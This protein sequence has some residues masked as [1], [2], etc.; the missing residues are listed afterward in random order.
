M[1]TQSIDQKTESIPLI[2]YII[3]IKTMESIC[4]DMQTV[5]FECKRFS[6]GFRSNTILNPY[7]DKGCTVS[8]TC[9]KPSLS[10]QL[11]DAGHLNA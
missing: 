7:K 2:F 3:F 9:L 11:N 4:G 10:K 8:R 6:G 5:T 1:H